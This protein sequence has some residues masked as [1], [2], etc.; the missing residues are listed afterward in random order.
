MLLV[1][2]AI[3]ITGAAAGPRLP[4]ADLART[5][6]SKLVCA[7]R[8]AATCDR[9]S[10]GLA[11]AYGAEIAALVRENAPA[12]HYPK[13]AEYLPVDHRRCR[14]VACASV[15]TPGPVWQTAVG[16]PATAFTRVVDCRPEGAER[17]AADGADC[18]G[19]RA[20]NLYLQFWFYYPD[21][22]TD[23]W[24]SAGYHPDDWESAQIR[25][26]PGGTDARASS[27]NSYACS[28]GVHNWPT[29]A[30]V[31]KKSAWCPYTGELHVS[32]G[33]HAGHVRSSRRGY[34]HTPAENLR[35]IPIEPVGAGAGPDHDFEVS[36][37]W[38]KAVYRDPETK[39]T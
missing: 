18:S 11:L 25:I 32:A 6:A 5:L 14:Q 13:G 30:G 3:A 26:G 17:A 7:A 8:L 37:P 33:S 19:R 38:L 22:R 29:D 10:E 31:W 1:A 23:P 12:V 2:L 21:S 28:N 16:L 24:G 35:L 27:H 20:G 39:G 9:G 36:P 4:G 34:R 15:S